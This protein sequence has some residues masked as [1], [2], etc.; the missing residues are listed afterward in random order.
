MVPDSLFQPGTNRVRLYQVEQTRA[1]P[2]LQPVAV[3]T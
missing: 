1:G 2:R 3:A